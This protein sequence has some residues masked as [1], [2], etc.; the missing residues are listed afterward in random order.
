[1][2]QP[3]WYIV[4]STMCG[5][6]TTNQAL[7]QWISFTFELHPYGLNDIIF[8]SSFTIHVNCNINP[9]PDD[10]PGSVMD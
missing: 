5:S 9:S 10:S 1:M 8:A 6:T 4:L 3:C 7:K 2:C